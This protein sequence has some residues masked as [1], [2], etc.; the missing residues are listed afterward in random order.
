MA[1]IGADGL[2]SFVNICKAALLIQLLTFS[3]LLLLSTGFECP[4]QL[5]DTC[6]FLGCAYPETSPT[7]GF[8]GKPEVWD[9]SFPTHSQGKAGTVCQGR[10]YPF[11]EVYFLLWVGS[12]VPL[13]AVCRLENQDI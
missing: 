8:S 9:K 11:F 12:F 10:L 13:T 4:Y 5:Y 2:L 1:N 3:E 7:V 6:H